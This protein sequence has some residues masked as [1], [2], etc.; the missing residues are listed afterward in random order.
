MLWS[1]LNLHTNIRWT[2]ENIQKNQNISFG[3]LW[4]FQNFC[5]SEHWQNIVRKFYWCLDV[6][7]TKSGWTEKNLKLLEYVVCMWSRVARSR[8][9]IPGPNQTF[10]SDFQKT[11]NLLELESNIHQPS[12]APFNFGWKFKIVTTHQSIYYFVLLEYL[13]FLTVHFQLCMLDSNKSV[14]VW[15]PLLLVMKFRRR[16]RPTMPGIGMYG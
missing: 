14:M 15:I 8:S 3:S 11:Q 2:I 6:V 7:L 4:N 1:I 16:N 9:G 5:L 13:F 12:L 10:S